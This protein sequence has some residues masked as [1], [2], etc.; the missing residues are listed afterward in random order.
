MPRQPRIQFCGACYHI[1]AR[2]NRREYFFQDDSIK[3]LLIK[4]LGEAAIRYGWCIHAYAIMDNHYHILLETSQPNLVAGMSWFQTAF[5]VRCNR[6]TGQCGHVFAGRYKSVL[7]QTSAGNYFSQ[8]AA[9]IHLNPA[10][11]GIFP[12]QD[13]DFL[14]A[15]RWTSLYWLSKP[16]SDTPAWYTAQK[17]LS[18]IPSGELEEKATRYIRLM[19]EIAR[20]EQ[21]RAGYTDEG[22]AETLNITLE[23]GWVYGHADF[24]EQ[25]K[26][27]IKTPANTSAGKRNDLDKA[28]HYLQQAQSSW[29]LTK[30]EILSKR[31]SSPEK[32]ALGIL[33]KE[34]TGLTC[35]AIAE[36]L[37]M[38]HS[39]S[40]TR[41][42]NKGIKEKHEQNATSACYQQLL[43]SMKNVSN[44]MS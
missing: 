39:V 29:K 19:E 35:R 18:H 37:N 15:H 23:R 44:I 31:K 25:M 36:L 38:G 8:L 14:H 6:Q 16:E 26:G 30:Q 9:Y 12:G 43:K 3:A 21:T 1:M 40:A 11:A 7:V 33:L 27:L 5:T 17:I 34:T 32:V 4:T 42:I 24:R 41:L 20:K 28:E 13:S 2:G 22:D 10:R